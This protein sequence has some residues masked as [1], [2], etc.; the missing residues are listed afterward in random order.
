MQPSRDWC[1][2]YLEHIRSVKRLAPQTV[3][4]YAKELT[5]LVTLCQAEPVPMN[6][7]TH[8]HIR[9]WIAKAHSAGLSGKTL[10]LQLSAWRGF[11]K[12]LVLQGFVSHNPCL[13]IKPPKVNKPLP[14]ALGIDA[15]VALAESAALTPPCAGGTYELARDALVVELLYGCG[16][17]VSELISLDIHPHAHKQHSGY[18]WIDVPS[19]EVHVF[20]KGRKR[21]TVPLGRKAAQALALYLPTRSDHL[22]KTSK[23]PPLQA[24]LLL[25]PKGER[26]TRQ[27]VWGLLRARSLQAGLAQSVH[28]HMLRHSFASHVLQSSGDLRAVQELLGHRSIASTQVY[29]RLDFQHLAKIYDNTHPRARLREAQPSALASNPFVRAADISPTSQGQTIQ[30]IP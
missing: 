24:A 11:F 29:T 12:W 30:E 2:L 25:S 27:A 23:A 17:R 20:G 19:R 21:R 16:L 6:A 14:K 8:N 22:A 15:A 10:A 5:R 3:D 26:L 1:A 4:L 7:L 28:P 18:G 9:R 13:D